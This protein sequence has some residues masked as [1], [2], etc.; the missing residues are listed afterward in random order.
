[1]M[2]DEREYGR[3]PFLHHR[4]CSKDYTHFTIL[5]SFL[6]KTPLTFQ[7]RSLDRDVFEVCTTQLQ[8][9]PA[10]RSDRNQP[11]TDDK[12]KTDKVWCKRA[13]HTHLVRHGAAK[14]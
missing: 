9:L 10:A 6:S 4:V 2:Y 13:K 11:V 5:M 3:P 14:Q 1:M 7:S 8:F 12:C